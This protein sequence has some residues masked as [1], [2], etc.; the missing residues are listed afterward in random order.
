MKYTVQFLLE[1]RKEKKP[2]APINIDVNFGGNRI[3]YYSGYRLSTHNWKYTH[4]W[5][6]D[7]W[8]INS[9]R[10]VDGC[11]AYEGKDLVS[12]TKINRLLNKVDGNIKDQFFDLFDTN[13]PPSKAQ[14]IDYLD[15]IFR[16]AAKL[17]VSTDRTTEEGKQPEL[18]KD[19]SFWPMYERYIIEAKVSPARRK[20]I[21]VTKNHL[22][23][24]DPKL[25]FEAVNQDKLRKFET[26]LLTNKE[27]PKS[28]NTAS[29]QLKKFRAFWNWAKKDFQNLH[30]PFEGYSIDAE[31]YGDP[32][33]L[34]K[35]EIDILYKAE[36]LDEK[37]KR[38]R[39]IFLLQCFL[40]ARVGDLIELKTD[41]LVNGSIQFVPRKTKD[42]KEV[43]VSIPLTA[44]AKEIIERYSL[45]DGRLLPFITQQRY[46]DYL[47]ELFKDEK[48]NLNRIVIRLNP[49]TREEEAVKIC[50]IASSHLARRTFV[51]NL[52]GKV[53]N[54]IIT[55]MT[56]HV[57]GSK[58]F[59]RYYSVNDELKKSALLNLE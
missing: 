2:F 32:I 42:N 59:A 40:G 6:P 24:F 29:G 13:M 11:K 30:Y 4:F 27:K 18:K 56:G 1:S 33:F 35:A 49:L 25:T 45:P 52:F 26:Y 17:K 10:V 31:L 48:V 54:S 20:Q 39:D 58:A 28:K 55:S 46:N 23:A 3:R 57:Q 15:G 44:R 36:L 50:D 53:D 5:I 12:S 14:V 8:D 43:S 9:K 16:K 21:K 51:G 38:V 37:L 41:N 22:K 34:T 7:N 47:K 19:I